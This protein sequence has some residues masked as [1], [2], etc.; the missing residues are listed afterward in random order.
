MNRFLAG[1]ICCALSGTAQSTQEGHSM[2]I[3]SNVFTHNG[4]IPAKYTCDGQD[5][6]PP[7]VWSGLPAG[8]RS[9]VLIVDDPDAPIRPRRA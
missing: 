6:S 9:L 7:L 8:T 3:N 4:P 1:L 2:Q 5:T